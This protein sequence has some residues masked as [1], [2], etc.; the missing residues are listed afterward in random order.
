MY[1]NYK[2]HSLKVYGGYINNDD[3]ILTCSSGGVA[4]A[5]ARQF[6][7]E[8][9]Y[10]VGVRYKENFHDAEY[11]IIHNINE[12]DKLKGS[13]Y[14]DANIND[15]YVNVLKLLE[16]GEKVLFIGLPCKVVALKNFLKK[17]FPNLLTCELICH[18]PTVKEV[19]KQ[20]IEHLEQKYKS[21]IIDFSVRKKKEKWIPYYLYAKFKNGKEFWKE[22]NKTEYG[23]AFS[24]L[25]L[26]RCYECKFKG[27]NRQGDIQIGDFWG[28]SET[29][30]Y[31]N[32]RG[33]SCILVHSEKGN[34]YLLKNKY[35]NIFEVEFDK[36]VEKNQSV[37]AS[38]KKHSYYENFKINFKEKGLFYSVKKLPL[39]LK[40][41]KMIPYKIKN[42]IKK[43]L[44]K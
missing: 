30:K 4:T 36:V 8:R 5:L 27:N 11:T 26:D 28:F 10:V 31:Y 2:D 24:I 35:L 6:I 15:V 18:G 14:I 25:S 39:K 19:H 17:D 29:E 37:I 7:D 38:L 32:D 12:I 44:N 33:T 9:G 13:K 22:F 23:I 42:F 3:E 43:I 20:Y 21:K 16:L 1:N 34:D 41:K 40:A